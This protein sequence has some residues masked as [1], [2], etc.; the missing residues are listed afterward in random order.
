LVAISG[1]YGRV[2]DLATFD[3]MADLIEA[4]LRRL[5]AWQA[6]PLPREILEGGG[7]FGLKTMVFTQWIQ[8]VL[9]PRLHEVAAGTIELPAESHVAAQAVREFDTWR[10]ATELTRLLIEV[11][12][13]VSRSN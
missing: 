2:P 13:L 5:N 3:R 1:Y 7:A 10:D 8:F 6:G 4:E 11:D 9:V 12:G